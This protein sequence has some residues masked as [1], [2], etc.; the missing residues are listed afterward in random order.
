MRAI[1]YSALRC[2]FEWTVNA[3]RPDDR[4]PFLVRVEKGWR[5]YIATTVPLALVVVNEKLQCSP[6]VLL[7][8]PV[9]LHTRR[10]PY[11]P[12]NQAVNK[13]TN[14]APLFNSLARSARRYAPVAESVGSTLLLVWPGNAAFW[15][16]GWKDR[17]AI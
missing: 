5:R 10:E 6:T 14:D 8:L 9:I 1:Q 7:S 12:A 17:L 16:V 4:K 13:R 3:A 2:G 15:V 11:T